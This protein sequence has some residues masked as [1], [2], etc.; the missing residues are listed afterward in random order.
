MKARTAMRALVVTL[1]PLATGGCSLLFVSEPPPTHAQMPYFTCTSSNVLP[2][3]DM[4][5]GTLNGIGALSALS[6]SPGTYEDQNQVV[7]IG[8][9][10]FLLSSLSARTGFQR[11][12]N[13]REATEQ[14]FLRNARS[15]LSP[16]A[17]AAPA[18]IFADTAARP[19]LPQRR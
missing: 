15:A 8:T 6:A 7:V 17:D 3:L 11:T 16:P 1:M 13:C 5:W 2:V 4:A 9:A 18:R 14:L 10:W 12:R 19:A